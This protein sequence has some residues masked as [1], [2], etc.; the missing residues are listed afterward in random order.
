[1][2]LDPHTGFSDKTEEEDGMEKGGM[3]KPLHYTCQENLMNCIKGQKDR[4]PKD[5]SPSLEGVQYAT[6]VKSGGQLLIAPVRMK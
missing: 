3:A 6:M 5:E 2:L 4:T 1:M